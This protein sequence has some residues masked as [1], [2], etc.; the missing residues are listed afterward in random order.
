MRGMQPQDF[1]IWIGAEVLGC[2]RGFQK[3][4]L[5]AV[6]YVVK[7]VE[8]GQVQFSMSPEFRGGDGASRSEADSSDDSKTE[9]NE[10]EAQEDINLSLEDTAALMRPTHC[11][12]YYTAQGRT[13]RDK[14]VLLLDVANKYFTL[15]HFI[16][17][18]SHATAGTRLRIATTEQQQQFMK[19][20]RQNP[21]GL[22]F[23]ERD[24]L[25]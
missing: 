21:I 15:R 22:R 12:V 4:V 6:T 7:G 3:K 24:F 8:E 20:V 25:E 13:L 10:E 17:G 2:T 16:V 1:K 23:G 11:I 18:V 9:E 5:N 19:N 14:N